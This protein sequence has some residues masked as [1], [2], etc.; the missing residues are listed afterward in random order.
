MKDV[1]RKAQ[2]LLL[3]DDAWKAIEEWKEANKY[4]GNITISD[5]TV[6]F[7]ETA[8]TVIFSGYNKE[9]KKVRQIA[10][11][12][13]TD[14]TIFWYLYVGNMGVVSKNGVNTAYPT[15]LSAIADAPDTATIKI[16][17]KGKAR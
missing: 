16:L 3:S 12:E 8:T 1:L 5:V 17:Q 9:T 14:T 15:L 10:K 13:N 6:S 11:C 7:G 2:Q 4:L